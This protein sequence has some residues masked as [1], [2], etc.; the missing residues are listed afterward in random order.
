MDNSDKVTRAIG[1]WFFL[2][3]L[4]VAA[5]AVTIMLVNKYQY[6]PET[7]VRAYFE[8]M[9]DGDGARALGALNA[10]VPDSNA[11]L[12]DGD[13]LAETGKSV[14]GLKI[15]TVEQNADRAVVRAEYTL[16]GTQHSTDYTLHPADTQ[17]GFFTV[18][19]FDRT[20]LPTMKVS[21]PGSTA[22][23][24]N[25]TSVALP[26]G[27]REFAVFYPGVYTG[28]YESPM[29]AAEPRKTVVT[30][31]STHPT[32]E[33]EAAAS[34]RL[35]ASVQEQIKSY[36]DSCAS[37]DSLYPA[38]C[39]FSYDFS[40]RVDGE[41]SW[42]IKEYPKPQIGLTGTSAKKW[43][44]A[45]AAGTAR[46]E[47]TSVDLFDGKKSK[48]SEDVPFGFSAD[49]SVTGEKATVTPQVR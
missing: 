36:L 46:I 18:W 25:G 11:A 47:F 6:G 41:V 43:S 5:A 34:D 24:I 38:G 4:A 16:D 27:S 3:V 31:R 39:P 26:D 49:L 40:G 48:V 21:M 2:I 44:L 30:G 14:E 1:A 33:L 15:S 35:K 29:V 23:D 20:T 13:A 8:A 32:L 42:R 7:D 22:V 9:R 45:D 19:D 17:W 37:K 28:S 12:L 10:D